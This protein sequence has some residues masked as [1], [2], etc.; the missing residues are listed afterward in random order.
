M[1]QMVCGG[2]HQSPLV[3]YNFEDCGVASAEYSLTHS[4]AFPLLFSKTCYFFTRFHFTH[5]KLF[6]SQSSD[7]DVQRRF[8]FSIL[9]FKLVQCKFQILLKFFNQP[10]KSPSETMCQL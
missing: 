5:P 3:V 2:S 1:I 9:R 7:S 10:S 4:L 8:R 6:Q